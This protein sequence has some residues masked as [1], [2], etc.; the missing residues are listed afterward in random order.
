M[1]HT[2]KKLFLFVLAI[3]SFLL[4]AC[5]KD[6]PSESDF[7]T[8][9]PVATEIV[10]PTP[11]VTFTPA[12]LKTITYYTISDA[13]AKEE[14]TAVLPAETV[15]TPEYLVEYV[16]DTM[17]DASVY[18]RVD[19]VTVEDKLVIVSF[20]EDSAPVCDTGERLE[21]EILDAIAQ[22]ILENLEEYSG[23]VFRVMDEGYC[24][25]NRSYD[26]NSVYLSH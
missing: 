24:S 1:K 21:G 19:S 17:T 16:T 10:Q 14:A 15:L 13:M 8:P 22:S 6:E 23:V 18:V 4:T 9:P 20:Q 25:E 2:E 26:R 5:Q 11:E 12:K 3:T 7:I